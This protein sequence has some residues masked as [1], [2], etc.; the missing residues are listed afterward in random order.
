MCTMLPLDGADQLCEEHNKYD[1][2]VNVFINFQSEEKTTL[3][4]YAK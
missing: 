1:S 3:Q 4:L 2:N